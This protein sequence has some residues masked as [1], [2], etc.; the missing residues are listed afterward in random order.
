[1]RAV[2]SAMSQFRNDFFP[3]GQVPETALIAARV[4]IRA[5]IR[6]RVILSDDMEHGT[7]RPMRMMCRTLWGEGAM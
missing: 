5:E 3:P 4:A 7:Y 6:D 2:S 1:M